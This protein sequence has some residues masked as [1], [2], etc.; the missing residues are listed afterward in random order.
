LGQ[1][2]TL[3]AAPHTRLLD[4]SKV[5]TAAYNSGL[6][7]QQAAGNASLAAQA[8]SNSNATAAAQSVEN[9]KNAAT[10]AGVFAGQ[11]PQ[12]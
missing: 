7:T 10:Q 1:T 8:I 5:G 2:Q 11:N 12:G 6:S 4:T 9:S 3:T